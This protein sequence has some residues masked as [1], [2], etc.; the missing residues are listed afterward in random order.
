MGIMNTNPT[1]KTILCFGDSN[2]FGQRSDD[3]HKGR[4]PVTVRWT[5]RLQEA[6]GSDYYVIEEGLSGRTTDVDY[7]AKPGRNG[8]AYLMPCLQ[9]HTP[10]DAVVLMLGTNDLKEEFQRSA[11]DIA[12]AVAGLV[13]DIRKNDSKTKI[14]VVSPIYI[15]A[16]APSFEEFYIPTYSL[17]GMRR[18]HELAGVLE[19]VALTTRS[20]FFDA[21]TVA[22]AGS[23]GI[24]F[25]KGSHW[26]LANALIPLLRET[27]RVTKRD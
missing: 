12:N 13:A 20:V 5:G 7:R 10:L 4:W 22:H 18:S 19:Q 2:T 9:S 15:D 17:A 11:Q 14:F 25:S 24:H 1:A 3:V 8:K 6:L 27:V 21:A 16:E 23:D 26:A